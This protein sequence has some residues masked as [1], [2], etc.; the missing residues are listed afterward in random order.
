MHVI[1]SLNLNRN[2]ILNMNLNDSV[3]R[4]RETSRKGG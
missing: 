1:L 4:V 2:M 3:L